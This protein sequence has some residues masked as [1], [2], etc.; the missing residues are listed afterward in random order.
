MCRMNNTDWES[1]LNGPAKYLAGHLTLES[2]TVDGNHSRIIVCFTSDVLVEEE[3]YLYIR[4]ALK[5]YFPEM[6][7]SLIIRSPQLKNAFL[8]N[9]EEFK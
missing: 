5:R 8:S 7:I 3:P 6:N 9:P 2:V 4:N 1:M